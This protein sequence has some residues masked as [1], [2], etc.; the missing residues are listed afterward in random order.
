MANGYQ[1]ND[2]NPNPNQSLNYPCEQTESQIKIRNFSSR[3]WRVGDR[4]IKFFNKGHETWFKPYNLQGLI[5]IKIQEFC[6]V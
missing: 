5:G 4:L 3:A 1:N 2:L 6:G